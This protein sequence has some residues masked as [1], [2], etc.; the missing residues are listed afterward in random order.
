[1]SAEEEAKNELKELAQ[2]NMR[3]MTH[4]LQNTKQEVLLFFKVNTYLRQ[5]DIRMGQPLNTFSIVVSAE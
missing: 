2:E 5:I 1:M 4:V 3:E